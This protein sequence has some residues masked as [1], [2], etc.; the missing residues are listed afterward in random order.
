MYNARILAAGAVMALACFALTPADAATLIADGNFDTP[1]AAG[2]YVT[3][4]AATS[5]G[6]GNVWTVTSGSVDE[7]GS[8]W[9]APPTGGGSVDLDGTSPGG[10]QQSFGAAAGSYDL[11]FYLSGNPDGAPS[12][13]EV[14]VTIDGTSSNYFYTIG[15]NSKDSMNYVLENLSFT[16]AGGANLLVFQSDDI[17]S[18]YGPV[19]G[20]V[21]V[22]AVPEPATWTMFILGFGAIG[23]MLRSARQRNNIATAVGC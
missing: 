10:I 21:S 19:I 8:Y 4:G 16:S 14:T 2:S 12:T 7:I 13:K 11:Q 1:L 23:W 18:P 15:G 3:Y 17:D 20:G 9:Q 22:S 5:F 6:A